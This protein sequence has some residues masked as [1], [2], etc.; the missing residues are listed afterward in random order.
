MR[1]LSLFASHRFYCPV[2]DTTI[3][4]GLLGSLSLMKTLPEIEPVSSGRNSIWMV[5]FCCNPNV[6]GHVFAETRKS[7]VALMSPISTGVAF[8]LVMVTVR[9]ALVVPT[10]CDPKLSDP[11]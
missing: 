3:L 1:Y 7:S 8:W 10:V 6:A 9:G 2:P 4:C 5:Q 11:C